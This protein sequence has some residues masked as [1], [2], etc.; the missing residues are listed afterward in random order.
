MTNSFDVSLVI[1]SLALIVSV[2]ALVTNVWLTRSKRALDLVSKY[3]E[4]E[5]G[6]SKG[7]AKWDMRLSFILLMSQ[8]VFAAFPFSVRWRKLMRDQLIWYKKDLAAWQ[9]EEPGYFNNFGSKTSSL[10]AEILAAKGAT[11]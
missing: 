3:V 9:K 4:L 7:N 8:A 5:A 2:V 10:V 1:S 11:K 6:W